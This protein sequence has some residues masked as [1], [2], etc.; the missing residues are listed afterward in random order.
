L[1]LRTTPRYVPPVYTFPPGT[2]FHYH[3]YILPVAN[4]MKLFTAV[5]YAF[6]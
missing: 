4:V 1:T 6:S 2:S 5:S 3:L